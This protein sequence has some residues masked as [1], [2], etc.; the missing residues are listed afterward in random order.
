MSCTTLSCP[1]VKATKSFD[2]DA[3]GTDATG[4]SFFYAGD[5]F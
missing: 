5:G 4:R 2:H 1:F 3:D